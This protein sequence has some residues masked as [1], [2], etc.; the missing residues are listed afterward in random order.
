[1]SHV[2]G[3]LVFKRYL[4][5]IRP[6]AG[7][8]P[9]PPSG[10][11]EFSG[12]TPFPAGVVT[13]DAETARDAFLAAITVNAPEPYEDPPWEV[14]FPANS[15]VTTSNGNTATVTAPSAVIS[16]NLAGRFNTS[17]GGFQFIEVPVLGSVLYTFDAPAIGFGL[18]ITDAGDFDAQWYAR[19]IDENLVSTDY[20]IGVPGS[21]SGALD[22]WGFIDTSGLTYVSVEI[23]QTVITGDVIGIDDVLIVAPGQTA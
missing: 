2:P 5:A 10:F 18:F 23:L 21:A 12:H 4:N 1:M 22:F 8:I 13:G 20:P 17:P 11:T 15:F 19:V 7:V 16:G 6:A 9:P 3:G 14:G